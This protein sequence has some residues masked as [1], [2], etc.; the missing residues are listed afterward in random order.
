VPQSFP[1]QV[2]SHAQTPSMHF[3]EGLP[4]A[5]DHAPHF[6][7]Q[8]SEP[9]SRPSHA[10]R[11]QAPDS[12]RYPQPHAQSEGHDSQFSATEPLHAPSPH[13]AWPLQAPEK[14]AY[15]FGQVP[16]VPAHPSLPQAFPAQ[17]GEHA[18]ADP[19]HET[20]HVA[21]TAPCTPHE[22]NQHRSFP[23]HALW[24]WWMH[25]QVPSAQ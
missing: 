13:P 15:P 21:A 11:T 25:W 19:A 20:A 9:Q 22:S 4:Q 3:P 24:C 17:S 5:P 7:P 2:G 16:Q 8:P 18:H 14:H 23:Q 10:K 6:P 12:H 1:A